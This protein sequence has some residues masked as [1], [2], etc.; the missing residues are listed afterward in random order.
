[1]PRIALPCCCIHRP[2][3]LSRLSCF[4]AWLIFML[5]FAGFMS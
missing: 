1:M 4:M 5:Q 3:W 2:A